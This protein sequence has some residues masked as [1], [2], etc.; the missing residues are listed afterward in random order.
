MQQCEHLFDFESNYGSKQNLSDSS[1][2]ETL[3]DLIFFSDIFFLEKHSNW[4]A[5][6]QVCYRLKH[7]V[8]VLSTSSNDAAYQIYSTASDMQRPIFTIND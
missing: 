7:L 8:Q 5:P 6:E 3:S 2:D 1:K 4:Q